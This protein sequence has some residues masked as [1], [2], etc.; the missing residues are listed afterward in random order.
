MDDRSLLF[1]NRDDMILRTKICIEIMMKF[2]LIVYTEKNKALKAEVIIIP[3]TS[4]LYYWQNLQSI[5][6]SNLTK[7]SILTNIEKGKK[8][9]TNLKEIYYNI[10]KTDNFIIDDDS[11]IL[12][13][14]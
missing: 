5:L 11:F 10:S 7:P 2:G 4:T 12:F 9:N 1:N 13:T 14:Y 8:L 3:S 6:N